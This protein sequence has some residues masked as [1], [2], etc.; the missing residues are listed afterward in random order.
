MGRVNAS[1]EAFNGTFAILLAFVLVFIVYHLLST[2]IRQ[3]MAWRR[4]LCHL[5]IGMQLALATGMASAGEFLSRAT[6]WWWRHSTGGD[7]SRLVDFAP[8]LA[9][10]AVVGSVG[11]LW[12]LRVVTRPLG[13]WPVTL[14]TLSV[15]VYLLATLVRH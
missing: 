10:A 3:H 15:V 12:I 11:F 6:V 2:G 9:T 14:A 7:A 1:L 5:S 4:W 8:Q 13:A